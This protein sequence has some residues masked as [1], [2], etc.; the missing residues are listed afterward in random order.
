MC[1]GIEHHLAQRLYEFCRI[2][3]PGAHL[4]LP[5]SELLG[6]MA[7][8]VIDLAQGLDVIGNKSDGNN[9]DLPN[10]LRC[11]LPQGVG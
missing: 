11:E 1:E 5:E 3:Q 4:E 9:A 2:I 8:F 7:R 10:L 6:E